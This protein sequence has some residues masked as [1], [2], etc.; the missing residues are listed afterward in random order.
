[1]LQKISPLGVADN[2]VLPADSPVDGSLTVGSAAELFA[3]YPPPPPPPP[4]PLPNCTET[5]VVSVV[6][7]SNA[8][9]LVNTEPVS[10]EPSP[11]RMEGVV[12]LQKT[13]AKPYKEVKRTAQE[14]LYDTIE[15]GSDDEKREGKV[16]KWKEEPQLL[17][18][19]EAASSSLKA[20]KSFESIMVA[21]ERGSPFSDYVSSRKTPE[22]L[23]V[24]PLRL[25]DAKHMES[26]IIKISTE[27]MPLARTK[28]FKRSVPKESATT[29]KLQ[30]SVFV[31]KGRKSSTSSTE[32]SDKTVF[33]PIITDFTMDPVPMK[34]QRDASSPVEL[35]LADPDNDKSA[36]TGTVDTAARPTRQRKT[37]TKYCNDAFVSVPPLP[38]R[39]PAVKKSK[40]DVGI[41]RSLNFD[42]D[43]DDAASSPRGSQVESGSS[44]ARGGSRKRKT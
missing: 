37:N 11:N 44:D 19:A 8:G 23:A 14:T 35:C 24:D 31:K 9:I 20:E 22:N 30:K 2:I 40:G 39:M 28:S 13:D 25:I 18:G 29:S 27:R 36:S 42:L 1:M 16:K 26:R 6:V 43:T 41:H 3:T 10:R 15:S 38:K 12:V 5:D 33:V 4:P 17:K 34:V 7:S 21:P 32:A